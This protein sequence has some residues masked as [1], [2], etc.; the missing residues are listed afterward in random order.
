MANAIFQ[1]PIPHNEPTL[2][3]APS[4]PERVALKNALADASGKQVEIPLVIAGQRVST[5][6]TGRSI[7]PHDHAHVLGIYHKAGPD[8][9]RRAVD[10][11]K[12]A[13]H[14]WSRMPWEVRTAVFLKAAD[15][16]TCRRRS[17]INAAAMLDLS[18]TVH[19]S[20]IDAIDELADYW[21][22]NPFYM[23]QIMQPQPASIPSVWN[24]VE[25]RP[26]EGFVFAV[27]PFNFAS[28]SGNLPTVP[29]MMGNTVV[30]KPASSAVYTAYSIFCVLEEAGLP[31]GVINLIPGDGS[32][33]GDAVL[34]HPDLAGVNF[35]GST[36]TFQQIWQAVG[37]DIRRYRNYPRLVGETGG[38]DFVFAHVSAD[39]KALVTALIRGSFEYQ[40][41]KCSASSR[42]Y[43]PDSI[44]PA[45][46]DR[47]VDEVKTIR[48]GDVAD[49][50]NFM[51]AV[52]DAPSFKKI[53]GYIDLAR[54]SSE[55]AIL[56]GGAYDDRTGYF[57]QPTVVLTRNP[58]HRMME[59]E[60]FGPVLTVFVY[61]EKEYEKTLRL[62][63]ATSPYG[64]T[65]SVF[66][67]DRRAIHTAANALRHAAGNFYIND[68]PTGAMVGLQPFGGSRASGT[69][70]KAGSHLNLQRW[71]SPRL[72]KENFC[73][74]TEFS[75]P[76]MEEK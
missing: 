57:V 28:I 63:D 19:Q 17:E 44:W 75:Y 13:W 9:V 10:A 3:Y 12:A 15:I 53:A 46:R 18:K 66:A 45:V 68:K 58:H 11:A 1:V 59:E 35:T 47:L 27:T 32:G 23:V 29:A 39:I 30:W 60:I 26:L 36:A 22:F 43:I 55:T 54:S 72:I 42:A 71:V 4:S 73:P 38:K 37:T 52:I 74:P 69:N 48:V 2:D 31:P 76:F 70:D 8:E 49:F 50:R 61:P 34:A 67:E 14:D 65:G 6:K 33:V 21:R 40:G 25:Q 41:Q 5:G 20:E 24:M 7:M 56:T 62:C 64:L 16:L 51:G